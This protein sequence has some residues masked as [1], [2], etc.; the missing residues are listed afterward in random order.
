MQHILRQGFDG[1]TAKPINA[2]I[3]WI[4]IRE[5]IQTRLMLL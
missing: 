4:K 3:L 5:L 1:Y 2:T